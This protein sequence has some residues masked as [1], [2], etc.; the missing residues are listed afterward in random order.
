MSHEGHNVPHAGVPQDE[1]D[2]PILIAGATTQS[3]MRLHVVNRSDSQVVVAPGDTLQVQLDE[4]AFKDALAQLQVNG[5]NLGWLPDDTTQHE[6]RITKSAIEY[7]NDREPTLVFT[8]GFDSPPAGLPDISSM[9]VSTPARGLATVYSRA[10]S[11]LLAN[12][13]ISNIDAIRGSGSV[14]SGG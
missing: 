2:S 4:V 7:A 6:V 8:M 1:D 11:H 13:L 3:W 14:S 10:L 9:E 5:R 12:Y